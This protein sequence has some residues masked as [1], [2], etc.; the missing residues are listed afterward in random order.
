MAVKGTTVAVLATGADAGAAGGGKSQLGPPKSW[1][2]NTIMITHD[3]T[4]RATAPIVL[5]IGNEI[6]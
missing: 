3:D 4:T 6:G 5:G 1:Y 2:I